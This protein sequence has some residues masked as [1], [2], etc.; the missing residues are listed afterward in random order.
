MGKHAIETIM[1][2]VVLLVAAGFLVFAYKSGNVASTTGYKLYAQ[3]DRVDGI[4][5]GSDVRI[6]GIKVGQV[7]DQK[8]DVESFLAK[9]S[10]TIDNSVKIPDDSTAEIVSDGL[11]GGKYL[12]ITPG[13]SE[14][15]LAEGG[16]I[17]FTQSSI[18]IESLIGK[19]M[20]GGAGEEKKEASPKAPEE[21][22]QPNVLD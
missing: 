12:S 13:G 17:K 22:G 6:S 20:Y 1:G 18:N 11:L 10:M 14:K 5:V 7:S 21:S 15:T 19:F 3:F 16:R 9:V 4:G 2:A 8:L